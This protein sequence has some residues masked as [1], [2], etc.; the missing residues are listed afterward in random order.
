MMVAS[1]IGIVLFP[2]M[3]AVA[4]SSD[5]LTMTISNRVSLILVGG[6][7]ALALFIGMSATDMLWHMGAGALVLLLA[8]GCFLIG[9]VGRCDR[10]LVR[11]RSPADLPALRVAPRRRAALST[12]PVP[13]ASAAAIP[14]R[15][16][17]GGTPASQRRRRALRHCARRRRAPDLSRHAL[18]GG[19]GDLTANRLVRTVCFEPSVSSQTPA[20]WRWYSPRS[21][22]L[23]PCSR[24]RCRSWPAMRSASA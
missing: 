14:R 15:A 11:L 22:R 3:M 20:A 23:R 13:D 7:F 18:D 10:A 16:R 5:L 21:R 8:F 12:D 24:W 19:R 17:M 9:L 1:A 2:A 6:F 4:A